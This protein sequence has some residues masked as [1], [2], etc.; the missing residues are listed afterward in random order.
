MTDIF[1]RFNETV[2]D[3]ITGIVFIKNEDYQVIEVDDENFY[4]DIGENNRKIIKKDVNFKRYGFEKR[5]DG[6]IFNS[7]VKESIE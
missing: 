1:L 6:T 5:L 2:P 3:N 4:V 7:F